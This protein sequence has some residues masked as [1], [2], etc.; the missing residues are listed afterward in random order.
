M[1]ENNKHNINLQWAP[2]TFHQEYVTCFRGHL[3]ISKYGVYLD[4][5][6]LGT[7]VVGSILADCC[8]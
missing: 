2:G 3:C 6:H 8:R 4:L 7:K 5:I 1:V